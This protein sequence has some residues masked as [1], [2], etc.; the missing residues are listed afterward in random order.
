MAD[1]NH[2][3]HN[4]Y[5]GGLQCTVHEVVARLRGEPRD[6]RSTNGWTISSDEELAD[7]LREFEKNAR[8]FSEYLLEK[9]TYQLLCQREESERPEVSLDD[10]KQSLAVFQQK[11]VELRSLFDDLA[12]E[13]QAGIEARRE[14]IMLKDTL[15]RIG[16][17]LEHPHGP[18]CE[19]ATPT[20][21]LAE[22]DESST[23]APAI[24]EAETW[25]EYRKRA[26]REED[27]MMDA[28]LAD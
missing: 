16:E 9:R 17:A 12:A 2:E 21:A 3:N 14:N 5:F 20:T 7:T 19:D 11:Q 28:I 1:E 13:T 15:Q 6:Q 27:E 25:S 24:E 23:Q 4:P 18:P 8:D 10:T 26:D 22:A